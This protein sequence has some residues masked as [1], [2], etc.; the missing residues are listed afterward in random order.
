MRVNDL[1]ANFRRH[2]SAHSSTLRPS[3]MSRNP[4]AKLGL[5]LHSTVNLSMVVAP[6]AP[7]G[8]QELPRSSGRTKV[9]SHSAG[10]VGGAGVGDGVGVVVVGDGVGDGLGD[11]LGLGVGLGVG[12]GVGDRLGG[13][14]VVVVIGV[15]LLVVAGSVV[16]VV[17]GVVGSVGLRVGDGVGLLVVA[18]FTV[19]MSVVV[20]L[21]VGD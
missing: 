1:H 4:D 2:R 9:V 21:G 7:G 20:V 11:G 12:D 5:R 6:H 15:G 19:N 16:V 3:T 14:S 10:G 17:V 8:G 18:G 13:S